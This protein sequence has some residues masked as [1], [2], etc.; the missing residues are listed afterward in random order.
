MLRCEGCGVMHHP[1][2]WVTNGGCGTPTQHASTPLAQAYSTGRATGDEAPHP[3]EGLRV[4]APARGIYPTDPIHAPR[5]AE[6]VP[7]F[8]APG[9]RPVVGVDDEGW[10]VIGGAGA[11]PAA[12]RARAE[13]LA[14]QPLGAP[15]GTQIPQRRY[16]PPPYE[17]GPRQM[18][19]VYGR[20]HLLRFWYVPVGLLLAAGAAFS[21]IWVVGLFTGGSST[22]AATPTT[23][24]TLAAAAGTTPVPGSATSAG[25]TVTSTSSAVA[26]TGPGKFTAGETLVVTGTTPDCLN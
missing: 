7:V 16:V 9:R 22:P 3:G 6:P 19:R 13:Y 8:E 24:P 15:A 26:T 23:A 25:Q 11:P 5:P 14:G 12:H 10:P 4:S 20:H 17:A 21:V 2:C 1:G 18:P